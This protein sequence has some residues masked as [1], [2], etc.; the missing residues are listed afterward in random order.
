MKI[1]RNLA[2]NFLIFAL[3]GCAI[4]AA[5]Y[6]HSRTRHTEPVQALTFKPIV[7]TFGLS[8]NKSIAS[9]NRIRN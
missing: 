3:C 2:L 1:P 4:V 8:T 6:L 5:F 9:T 7:D